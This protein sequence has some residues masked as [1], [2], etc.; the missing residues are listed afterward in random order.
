[1]LQ[2]KQVLV[3]YLKYI[4]TANIIQYVLSV[5]IMFYK[6]RYCGELQISL[7]LKSVLLNL[8]T[9]FYG[10]KKWNLVAKWKLLSDTGMYSA[11]TKIIKFPKLCAC[12]AQ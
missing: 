2:N 6:F 10:I 5:S 4:C 3:K 9:I 12:E 7:R 1:M 11:A 8:Y